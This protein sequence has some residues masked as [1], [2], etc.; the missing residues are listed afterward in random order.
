[1]PVP[2]RQSV[3]PETKQLRSE[4]STRRL[5]EAASELIAEQGYDRTTL[6]AIGRRAGYSHGLVTQRFGSKE[7]LL[8]ALIEYSTGVA[9]DAVMARAESEATGPD[10]LIEVIESVRRNIREAPEIMRGL[11]ALIFEAFKPIPTLHEQMSS[12]HDGIRKQIE[13]DIRRGVSAGVMRKVEPK[14][15]ARFF[16]SVLRGLEYQWLLEPDAFDIDRSLAWFANHVRES[17]TP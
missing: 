5:L 15:Y 16:L 8:T 14:A 2:E 7:G 3:I 1:M 10:V 4:L 17:L 11:Y 12:L 13:R 6:Q 9:W